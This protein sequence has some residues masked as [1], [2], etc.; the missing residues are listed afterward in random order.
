MP[1]FALCSC[2]KSIDYS[3]FVSENR[4]DVYI[5]Q[6]DGVSL[7]IY[8]SDKET[9]YNA[10]GV[11]GEMTSVCEVYYYCENTPS[12]VEMDLNGF[13]GEMNYLA[14]SRSFYLSFS[15]DKSFGAK[16]TVNLIIDG[17]QTTIDANNVKEDGTIDAST[18][19][20]CVT[21]Y[22]GEQFSSLT[23]GKNFR[24]EI[25]VRL[26]F[27]EGCYYYVG[28][29][30]RDGNTHAYLL[31]ATDGRIISEREIEG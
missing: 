24:G 18:A 29:I 26:L 25:G 2:S 31:D 3:A 10:D 16:A 28:V 27:D 20:K 4:H 1:F 23:E 22:D 15:C 13:G 12:E 6:D 14:V 8:L 9:P 19:L 30:D 21:E 17:K 11:K 5:Y 7:K